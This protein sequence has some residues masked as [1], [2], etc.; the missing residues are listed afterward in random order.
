MRHSLKGALAAAGAVVVLVGG[1]G[2]LAFWTDAV[3]LP[4]GTGIAS[5]SLKLTD[6]TTGGCAAAGWVLDSA[7]SPAGATFV[8]ATGRLVPGDVLTKTC[9]FTVAATGTHLTAGIAVTQPT[10]TGSLASALTVAGTFTSGG[11]PVTTLTSANDGATITARITLTFDPA[12]GNATQ[13]TSADIGDYG[14]AVT[15]THA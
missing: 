1:S 11:S 6:T 5:G 15:Q 12:S 2:T 10:K 3:T 8:P 14:V 4:G 13:L 7:A 9:T